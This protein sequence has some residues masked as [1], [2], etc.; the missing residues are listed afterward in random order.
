VHSSLKRALAVV[1]LAT[2]I[3]GASATVAFADSAAL[4]ETTP[5]DGS[6]GHGTNASVD[7]HGFSACVY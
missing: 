6:Q 5:C 4:I 7:G 2:G 1:V 3:V